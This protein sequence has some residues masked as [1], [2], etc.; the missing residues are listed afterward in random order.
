MSQPD[1]HN[2]LYK[3]GADGLRYNVFDG[4]IHPDDALSVEENYDASAD[5]AARV[6]RSGEYSTDQWG[7][8]YDDPEYGQPPGN[9]ISNTDTTTSTS[10]SGSRDRSTGGSSRT[11]RNTNWYN[12]SN[13]RLK[14]RLKPE[15]KIGGTLRYPYEALTDQTDYLQF[16]IKQYVPLG[17]NSL[18]RAPGDDKRYVKGGND[19]GSTLPQDLSRTSRAVINDGTI[20]L[21]IPAQIQDSNSVSYGD[22]SLNGLQAA[23]ITAAGGLQN[24]L[25][26][27]I[28]D[29]LTTKEAWENLRNDVTSTVMDFGRTAMGGIGGEEV[30][31]DMLL[32]YF[33]AQAVSAL[34]GNV[35]FNEVLARAEGEIMNPNMELLFNGPTLRAFKFSF[36]MTPRNPMEANQCGL[37]IRAFKR[38]MAAKAQGTSQSGSW[39]LKTPNVFNLRYRS[40]N[41]D[42]PFLHKFKQCFLT[43]CAVN[44]TADGVY[45][46]YEDATPTAMILDLSFK[47]LEPIYDKDYD[48]QPGQE[49]VGY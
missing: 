31:S 26:D 16:D 45:A 13:L 39:F 42:H 34:G 4:M 48:L 18:V 40:G 2:G 23:G 43:D 24:N 5:N 3:L 7:R 21:P 29:G 19:V 47:E 32:K 41:K 25:A 44:Y 49:A 11:N 10:T 17:M 33:S 30:A 46:T 8:D 38:N 9:Y 36:K 35:T 28:G 12:F 27:A 22:S 20:L 37:I 15:E 14:E 1:L 6:N